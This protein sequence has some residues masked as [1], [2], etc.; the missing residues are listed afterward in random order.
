MESLKTTTQKALECDGYGDDH[1]SVG[2]ETR[3]ASLY[4]GKFHTFVLLW[5]ENG[6][7]FYVDGIQTNKLDNT[8]SNFLGSCTVE[9]YLKITTECGT[10]AGTI[11]KNKLPDALVV[12]Y[13]R[14]YKEVD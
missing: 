7:Y 6:Y 8:Q 12:D 9:T 2:C 5:N 4:D 13:V 14:V 10:W 1:K 11:D 3:K